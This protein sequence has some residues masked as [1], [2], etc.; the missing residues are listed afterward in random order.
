MERTPQ[1]CCALV[2]SEIRRITGNTVYSGPF[3]GMI[4]TGQGPKP[5][6]LLGTYEKELH[7]TIAAI[8]AKQFYRIVN[9]GAC[10]GYY[11]VG[12]ARLYPGA[13]V[14]AFEERREAHPN[15]RAASE[16][17]KVS[18]EIHGGCGQVELSAAVSHG[19]FVLVIMDCEGE[20][21]TLLDLNAVPGLRD[22]DILVEVHEFMHAG[23]EAELHGRFDA[24]H[25]ITEI[26]SRITS[27]D[28]LPFT[29][30]SEL[31]TEELKPYY[32]HCIE[33]NR[34]TMKWFYMEPR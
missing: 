9:V 22:C 30:E 31:F 34:P 2:Q 25:V 20:E 13:L 11:A 5:Y 32:L 14:I 27:L 15:L 19:A 29:P 33:E 24:S 10:D 18:V 16:I 12:L 17:N 7:P 1:E 8:T 28:D 26:P 23:L 6:Y 21:K 4:M 3:K